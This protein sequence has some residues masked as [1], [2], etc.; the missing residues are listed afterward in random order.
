[1]RR[2][3]VPAAAARLK[4]RQ[5]MALPRQNTGPH[6]LILK[7]QD[8]SLLNEMLSALAL[9]WQP[10]EMHVQDGTTYLLLCPRESGEAAPAP[11]MQQYRTLYGQFCE[12]PLAATAR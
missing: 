6:Y 4:A 2:V 5:S 10:I 11:A 1:M 8:C 12:E 7:N 9:H 3:A